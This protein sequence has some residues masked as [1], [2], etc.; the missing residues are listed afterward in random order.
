MVSVRAN[1]LAG[2]HTILKPSRGKYVRLGIQPILDKMTSDDI[3]HLLKIGLIE[4]LTALT[5]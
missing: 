5:I 4:I 3:A 1:Y 2:R